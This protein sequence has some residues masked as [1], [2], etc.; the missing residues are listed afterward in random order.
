MDHSGSS[1]FF[2]KLNIIM[3]L[4]FI[5]SF[6]S[7]WSYL[8]HFNCLFEL[9]SLG[10]LHLW[11]HLRIFKCLKLRSVKP[12][13]W[14]SSNSFL[15]LSFSLVLEQRNK[16]FFNNNDSISFVSRLRSS[17]QWSFYNWTLRNDNL[18]Q[19]HQFI[20]RF[21]VSYL[22]LVCYFEVLVQSHSVAMA[23]IW[24]FHDQILLFYFYVW[25]KL[26]DL[27]DRRGKVICVLFEFRV[28]DIRVM[29]NLFDIQTSWHLWWW[30]SSL[31]FLF[32]LFDLNFLRVF[33]FKRHDNVSRQLSSIYWF[34]QHEFSI[35]VK[36]KC[37]IFDLIIINLCLMI[38][39]NL[40]FSSFSLFLFELNLITIP[41][42]S[43]LYISVYLYLFSRIMY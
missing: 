23:W 40:K 8:R 16:V 7:L 5:K 12:C 19:R 30:S 32:L 39:L 13:H 28:A 25:L 26:N 42:L 6:G 34:N 14:S 36:C 29:K 35:V 3:N 9:N 10:L 22:I 43:F 4:F 31:R 24:S 20:F 11:N 41:L 15:L 38:S 2:N 17:S 18:R 33:H 1:S 21:W 37:L 27:T